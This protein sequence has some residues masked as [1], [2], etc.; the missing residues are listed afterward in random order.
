MSVFVMLDFFLLYSSVLIY[1]RIP[2]VDE[3]TYSHMQKIGP[4]DI[5]AE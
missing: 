5:P 1:F 4:F 3:Q 2:I